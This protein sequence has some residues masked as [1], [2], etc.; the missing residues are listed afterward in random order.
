[1]GLALN[2]KDCKVRDSDTY[3]RVKGISVKIEKPTLVEE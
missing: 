2:L 3:S 1:M